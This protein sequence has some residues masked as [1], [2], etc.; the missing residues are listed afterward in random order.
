M[1][2]SRGENRSLE[3]EEVKGGGKGGGSDCLWWEGC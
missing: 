3:A 2:W 1:I